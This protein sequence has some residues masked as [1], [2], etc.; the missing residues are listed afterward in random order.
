ML[1]QPLIQQ[2]QD[3]RLRGMAAA[4][5]QQLSSP[6]R[7]QLSFE[8]RLGL[9]IQHEVTDRG[10]ARLPLV[11][12]VFNVI[13]APFDVNAM[14]GLGL[15]PFEFESSAAQFDLGLTVDDLFGEVRLTYSTDLFVRPT[16]ERLL[17][18]FL[19]LMAQ[20]V[21]DPSRRLSEYPPMG[22]S[23]VL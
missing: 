10:S 13:N 6:D 22:A 11:Q 16:A 5:E 19:A 14:E 1:I 15:A 20:V 2:L 23:E 18:R 4:L 9:M 21:A 8:E 17:A 3:L 12:V 7:S